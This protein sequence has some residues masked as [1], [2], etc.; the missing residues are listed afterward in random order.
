MTVEI[1]QEQL[2]SILGRLN[3]LP[4]KIVNRD[5]VNYLATVLKESIRLRTLSGRDVNEN[6]FTSYSPEYAKKEGK[7]IV[8]LTQSGQMLSSMTQKTL[9]NDSAMIFFASAKYQNGL[10]TNDL[11]K[12]HNQTGAGRNRVVREFFGLNENLDLPKIMK[13]Y[14]EEI[15][16]VK[17]ELK[18]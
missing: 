10:S 8:N 9:S 1:N 7:R 12:I 3:N 2:N 16:R 11:A 18:L 15:T 5:I 17:A 13:A 4:K 14:Q 6:S